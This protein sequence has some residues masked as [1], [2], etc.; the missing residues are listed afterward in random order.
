MS[1]QSE[2]EQVRAFME[3]MGFEWLTEDKQ[4]YKTLPFKIGSFKGKQRG[5]YLHPELA[6][7]FYHATQAQV[8]EARLDECSK[9][10]SVTRP[11]RNLAKGIYDHARIPISFYEDMVKLTGGHNERG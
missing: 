3:G 8:A 6:T 1:K 4:W 11:I 10:L 5:Q 9:W 2:A 7:F